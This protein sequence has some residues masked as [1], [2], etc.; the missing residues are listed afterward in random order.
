M[1][2]KGYELISV[3]VIPEL[4]TCPIDPEFDPNPTS[5]LP[6][7]YKKLSNVRKRLIDKYSN[8]FLPKLIDQATDVK[9]RYKRVDHHNLK[10]GDLVL[11]KETF[12]KPN[13]YPLAIVR[14]ININDLDEVTSVSVFKGKTRELVRRHVQSIIPLLSIEADSQSINAREENITVQNYEKGNKRPPRTAAI[15]G[16]LNNRRLVKAGLV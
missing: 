10:I 3:N 2:V 16:N 4:V 14:E 9:G 1:L 15:K 5:N 11:L 13:N 7:L 6:I 12:C 8:E